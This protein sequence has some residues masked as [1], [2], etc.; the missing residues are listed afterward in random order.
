MNEKGETCRDI[1]KEELRLN[2]KK[3]AAIPVKEAL[4]RSLYQTRLEGLMKRKAE[5]NRNE[6]YCALLQLP[7]LNCS[8]ED[9]ECARAANS[10]ARH[11]ELLVGLTPRMLHGVLLEALWLDLPPEEKE[12]M[13]DDEVKLLQV[14]N[15]YYNISFYKY[16]YMCMK[17]FYV[18]S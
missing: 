14:I 1:I 10:A 5:W 7:I 12:E 16:I 8:L 18:H 17:V 9:L 13:R 2:E 15:K 4:V 6:E 3:D 11:D